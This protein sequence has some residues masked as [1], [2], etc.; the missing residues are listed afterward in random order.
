MTRHE[1]IEA[2]NKHL[3]HLDTDKLEKVLKDLEVE[4]L[5]LTGGEGGKI[6]QR[7]PVPMMGDKGSEHIIREARN[8]REHSL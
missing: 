8:S 6:G 5:E 2:I 3:E 1:A 7:K 4:K